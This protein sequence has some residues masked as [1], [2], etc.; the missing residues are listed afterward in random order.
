MES[1][2]HHFEGKWGHPSFFLENFR[3]CQYWNKTKDW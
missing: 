3:E 2:T 1:G